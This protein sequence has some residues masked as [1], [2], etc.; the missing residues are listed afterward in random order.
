MLNVNCSLL[1]PSE[2]PACALRSSL[3]NYIAKLLKFLSDSKFH[4]LARVL[5]LTYEYL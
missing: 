4:P 2:L 3:L 5:M 1:Q